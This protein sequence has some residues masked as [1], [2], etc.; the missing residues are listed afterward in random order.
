MNLHQNPALPEIRM[1]CLFF[2]DKRTNM[3]QAEV[4]LMLEEYQPPYLMSIS[5]I[6]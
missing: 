2:Q 3:I 1:G 4:M 6:I 5:L